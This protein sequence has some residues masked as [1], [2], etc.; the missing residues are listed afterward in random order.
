[1]G[2]FSLSQERAMSSFSFLEM[3]IASVKRS[4]QSKPMREMCLRPVTVFTPAWAN[5]LLIIPSF[6][7]YCC[8]S[9]SSN[10]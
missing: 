10:F 7:I 3:V 9:L 5:A 4:T 6:M 1:M 8:F 2:R